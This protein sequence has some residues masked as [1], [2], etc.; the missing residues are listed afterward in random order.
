MSAEVD[1]AAAAVVL[2]EEAFGFPAALLRVCLLRLLLL[3]E[4]SASEAA[5]LLGIDRN[6]LFRYVKAAA[7]TTPDSTKGSE[8]ASMG[9]A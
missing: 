9:S 7:K 2:D 4:E 3:P 1:G 6:T 5:R 8:G